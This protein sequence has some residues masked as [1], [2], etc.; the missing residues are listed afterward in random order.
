MAENNRIKMALPHQPD[1]ARFVKNGFNDIAETYDR[2][3]DFMTFG[4]HR[5][6]KREVLRLAAL[7]P[8][9]SV[10]DICTGTGDLAYLA[11]KQAGPQGDVTAIDFAAEMLKVAA[12]RE[13]W[14]RDSNLQSP[15]WTRADATALPFPDGRFNLVT[16]G[17]GL[18]NVANLPAAL[19]EIRRVLAKGG[20]FVSLDCCEPPNPII[21]MGYRLHAFT[22]IPLLGRIISGNTEMYRYLPASA[23]VFED[24]R[25]LEQLLRK[26]G[27]I[28]TESHLRL[29]GSSAIV[30]GKVDG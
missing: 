25:R 14:P 26:N 5:S 24:P 23:A 21:R 1:K 10:L 9:E 2:L 3:N 18:R 28:Y 11:A 29:W 8:G 16:V 12:A 27:F 15:N 4:M 6:W 30:L 20:R 17:Y 19:Q 7:Q 22:V 13:G